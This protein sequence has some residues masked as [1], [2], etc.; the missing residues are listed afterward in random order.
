MYE[1]QK[2]S[3]RCGGQGS[4]CEARAREW[5]LTEKDAVMGGMQWG[6]GGVLV[7]KGV[8]DDIIAESMCSENS[9][10]EAAVFALKE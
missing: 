3:N 9:G 5:S 8:R 10:C 1:W 7:S 2:V 6:V 4:E